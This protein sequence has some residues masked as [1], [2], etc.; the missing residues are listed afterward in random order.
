M[1][2]KK[3]ESKVSGD[4][5]V[6]SDLD[7]I[8]LDDSSDFV[9]DISGDSPEPEQPEMPTS[10]VLNLALTPIVA[11]LAPNWQIKPEEIQMLS[12]AYGALL[13]KYMPGVAMGVEVTAILCTAM[14]VAPRIG[15]P[16]K[17]VEAEGGDDGDQP[18]SRPPE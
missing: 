9:P 8:N 5:E 4:A 12:E 6:L 14:V 10:E 17:V 7:N 15:T 1:N 2:E 18:E 11:I 13:D 16:L 3:T